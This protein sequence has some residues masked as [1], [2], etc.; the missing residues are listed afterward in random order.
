MEEEK[1]RSDRGGVQISQLSLVEET[2]DAG[3]KEGKLVFQKDPSTIH[4]IF[5]VLCGFGCGRQA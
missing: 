3:K 4:S 1:R 5:R 2:N